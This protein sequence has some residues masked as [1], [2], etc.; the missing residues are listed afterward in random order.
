MNLEKLFFK[1]V[2]LWLVFL[3]IILSI[4]SVF[5]FG[6]LVTKS[7]TALNIAKA[8]ASLKNFFKDDIAQLEKRFGNKKGLNI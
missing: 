8:P 6:Y 1:K 4:L 5:W 2:S 7:N 3:I